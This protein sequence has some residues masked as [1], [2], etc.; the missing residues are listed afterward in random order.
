VT[1]LW[2]RSWKLSI[3]SRDLTECD[4]AFKTERH[5]HR[6]P[7]SAEIRIWNVSPDTRAAI[8]GAA[9]PFHRPGTPRVEIPEGVVS[10]HA[11]HGED[12]PQVFRGDV[13]VAWTEWPTNTD[14][15]LTVTARD[16]GH[17]YSEGRCS[18]A[19]PAGVRIS[20]VARY[21]L[22]TLDIGEG[23]IAEFSDAFVLRSGT[24]RL[25]DGYVAHGRSHVV[26]S[27][28]CRAAGLRWS[29]QSGA[30]QLQ[31]LGAPLETR[32]VLLAADSGLV[33]SPTWDDRGRRTRGRRGRASVQCLIIPGLDPGRRVRVESDTVEGDFEIRKV[34]L[35]GDTRGNEWFADL[36]LRPLSDVRPGIR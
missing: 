27:D 18:R 22:G 21:V 31:R 24:D 1:D 9:R 2:R 15:V 16:G 30:L 13:R 5:I 28:L 11:G 10:L 14:S 3:G 32:S 12:P 29:V 23:N 8:E 26:F 20:D 19:F 25:A 35:T 7:N 36:E 33:G 17:A 4:L 34:G 6:A